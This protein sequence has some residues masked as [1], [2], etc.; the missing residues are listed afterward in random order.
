MKVNLKL[1]IL[2]DDDLPFM[3][4]G[5]ARLLQGIERLGSINQAAR[6]MEMSYVKAWKIINNMEASLGR[7]ILKKKTKLL[8]VSG[9]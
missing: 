3:G 8:N 4:K 9:R 1:S 7:K 6:E 2:N 5:P